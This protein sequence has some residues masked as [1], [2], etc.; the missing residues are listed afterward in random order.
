[1]K[2]CPERTYHNDDCDVQLPPFLYSPPLSSSISSLLKPCV[3]ANSFLSLDF[4]DMRELAVM[5]ET[6]AWEHFEKI[7]IVPMLEKRLIE[8]NQEKTQNELILE[9]L[10]IIKN[11]LQSIHTPSSSVPPNQEILLSITKLRTE[12][13]SR[14]LVTPD[15]RR[16][17][18]VFIPN[19]ERQQPP[20]EQGQS[21]QGTGRLVGRIPRR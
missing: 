6:T 21:I 14:G 3:L 18:P 2:T 16:D 10:Q 7:A 11:V 4:V 12:L 8:T 20:S 1:M 15:V 17:R 9:E 19:P 5:D 13:E